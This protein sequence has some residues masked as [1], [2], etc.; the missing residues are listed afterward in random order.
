MGGGTPVLDGG[1]VPHQGVPPDRVPPVQVRMGYPPVQVRVRMGYRPPRPGIGYPLSRLCY[2]TFC[3]G[4]Y[5]S[6]GF[7]QEDFLVVRD[8]YIC[9]SCPISPGIKTCGWKCTWDKITDLKNVSPERGLCWRN[10]TKP[11]ARIFS[12][13]CHFEKTITPPTCVPLNDAV[14]SF[15]HELRNLA[16]LHFHH[17]NTAVKPQLCHNKIYYGIKIITSDTF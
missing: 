7:S 1:G 4:R 3:R 10:S 9:K 2:D 14:V 17:K 11:K 12:F 13:F 8:F 15:Q 5:A 16:I 6:S